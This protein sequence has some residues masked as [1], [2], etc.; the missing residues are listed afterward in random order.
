MSGG[1]G[2]TDDGGGHAQVKELEREGKYRGIE[3]G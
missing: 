3:E 2:K 1:R